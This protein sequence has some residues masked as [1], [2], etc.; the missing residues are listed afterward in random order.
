M[1]ILPSLYAFCSSCLYHCVSRVFP[2]SFP[3]VNNFSKFKIPYACPCP[4]PSCICLSHV[5]RGIEHVAAENVL[6]TVVHDPHMLCYEREDT[7]QE[8]VPLGLRVQNALEETL[9]AEVDDIL[10]VRHILG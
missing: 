4:C 6:H 3:N 8:D 1:S 9:A 2:P 7:P 5:R 10:R